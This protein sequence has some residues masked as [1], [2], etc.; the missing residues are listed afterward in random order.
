MILRLCPHIIQDIHEIFTTVNSSGTAT[1]CNSDSE[2]ISSTFLMYWNGKKNF[3][4][5]RILKYHQI[6]TLHIIAYNFTCTIFSTTTKF[7]NLKQVRVYIHYTN[8][9]YAN[10]IHTLY[11]PVI[12]VGYREV[13]SSFTNLHH[14]GSESGYLRTAVHGHLVELS[15]LSRRLFRS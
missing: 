4:G 13:V 6:Q 2:L 14:T 7:Q 10:N 5:I 12:N 8:S 15:V 9:M 1:L 11:K 3:A